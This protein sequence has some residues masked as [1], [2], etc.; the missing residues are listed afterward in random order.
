MRPVD[1][2]CYCPVAWRR[3]WLR[4]TCRARRR[5]KAGFCGL[6]QKGARCGI[7]RDV[8]QQLPATSE[9]EPG[10]FAGGDGRNLGR[11]KTKCGALFACSSVRDMSGGFVPP[12][13]RV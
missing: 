3:A 13:C 4:D 10:L 5:I 2:T 6:R 7:L 12:D 8:G 1:I 11:E 9:P